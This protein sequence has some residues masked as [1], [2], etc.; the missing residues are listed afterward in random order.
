VIATGS[1]HANGS[2]ERALVS[3]LASLVRVGALVT[4]LCQVVSLRKE[5]DGLLR[6]SWRN[7]RINSTSVP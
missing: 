3:E 6:A 7:N 4:G 5:C 2:G 1:F